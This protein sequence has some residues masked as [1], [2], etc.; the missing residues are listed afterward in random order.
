MGG[1][2]DCDYGAVQASVDQSQ[3]M[4]VPAESAAT[5]VWVPVSDA[6]SVGAVMVV[7]AQDGKLTVGTV[8]SATTAAAADFTY[9]ADSP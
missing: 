8:V 2:R 6:R 3:V 1:R 4:V 9:A 5:E 7:E